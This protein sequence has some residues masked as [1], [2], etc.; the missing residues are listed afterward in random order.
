[1]DFAPSQKLGNAVVNASA[2]SYNK[3]EETNT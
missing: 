3:S 1:M 2:D